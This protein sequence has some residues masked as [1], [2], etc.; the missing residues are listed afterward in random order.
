MSQAD[1]PDGDPESGRIPLAAVKA[2]SAP[3]LLEATEVLLLGGPPVYTRVEVAQKCDVS[4][5]VAEQLWHSLGFPHF[6]DDA[7]V[8]TEADVRAL[9]QTLRLIRAGILD[10][11]SQAAMVRTWGRSFAR[12]AEWQTSL[13]ASIAVAADDPEARM[14]ELAIDVIPLVDTLQSYIWRRHLFSAS[15]RLLLRPSDTEELHAVGFVDIVGYTTQSKNLTETE[16]VSLV[17]HFED[18]AT[19]T[20]TDHGGQLIKTIGDEVLFAADS[21]TEA[22]RIACK[23]VDRHSTDKE[24]PQV[25]AG[26]AYGPVVRRLGDVF[27]PTVNIASR[28][29]S[30][31]KPGAVLVDKGMREALQ[32]GDEDEEEFRLRRVR[33]A[34]VKGYHR[35]EPWRLKRGKSAARSGADA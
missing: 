8:F 23:L 24:F 29:T 19:S 27:G 12:L 30:L 1:G 4:V 6:G 20:V 25:R 16:L 3:E 21:P 14:E 28:L 13:L 35:L 15:S 31:S 17:E 5:Q 26:V 22:A 33:R 18:V 9:E 10:E 11:D 32:S 34:S 2:L 7:V